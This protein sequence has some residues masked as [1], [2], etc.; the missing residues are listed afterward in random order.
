MAELMFYQNPT[1]LSREQ[2]KDLKYRPLTDFSF[3]NCTNSVPVLGAEFME[4]SRDLPIFFSEKGQDIGFPM[5]LLSLQR[6]THNLLED[7]GAWKQVYAPAFIRRYP[8]VLTNEKNVCF[9]ADSPAFDGTGLPLFDEEGKN[10]KLLEGIVR[11]LQ[12]FDMEMDNTQTFC[13]AL[14][15]HNLLQ[16]FQGQVVTTDGRPVRLDNLRI[17]NEQAFVALDDSIII[18]WFRKGWVAWIYAHLHS[19]GA[20]QRVATLDGPSAGI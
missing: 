18:D 6:N 3:S 10:T 12:H 13:R 17:V 8:F 2:H 9:D 20:L 16:Q 11:F 7:T 4:A 15:E 19:I 14:E 5:A 1:V